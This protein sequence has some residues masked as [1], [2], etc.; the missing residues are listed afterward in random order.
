[1]GFLWAV[2]IVISLT[3]LCLAI[4]RLYFWFV[5]W[6]LSRL[7]EAG[8]RLAPD[9]EEV[10]L[11]DGREGHAITFYGDDGNSVFIKELG[12][13]YLLTGGLARIE[14]ADSSWFQEN[15]ENLEAAVITMTPVLESEN[16]A[17]TELPPLELTVDVPQS[18]LTLISPSSDFSCTSCPAPGCSSTAR[19]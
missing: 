9:V 13:S 17:R 4:Y 6:R 1:M 2:L 16:G 10:V 12:R 15:P 3:F 19:T 5:A 7:Y 11:D 8:G 18:P 14:V